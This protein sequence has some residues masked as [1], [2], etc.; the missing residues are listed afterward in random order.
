MTTLQWVTVS[1]MVVAGLFMI[2]C[3]ITW[4]VLDR[5]RNR[6]ARRAMKRLR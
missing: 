1:F 3:M 4:A 2:G 6:R 5:W